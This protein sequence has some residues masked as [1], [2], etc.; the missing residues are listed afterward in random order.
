MNTIVHNVNYLPLCYSY[1]ANN[2]QLFLPNTTAMGHGV[3]Y[4]WHQN[5]TVNTGHQHELIVRTDNNHMVLRPVFLLQQTCNYKLGI[6][7]CKVIGTCA[8]LMTLEQT[9]EWIKAL[10][11][12]N[13]W[14]EADAYALNF[15]KNSITGCVLTRLNHEI[16]KF[17][18]GMLNP[19]HRIYILDLIRQLFPSLNHQDVIRAPTRLSQL[20][21]ETKNTKT[22]DPTVVR[23]FPNPAIQKPNVLLCP[24][25]PRAGPPCTDSRPFKNSRTKSKV[26]N[27]V[28]RNCG[29]PVQVGESKWN[30]NASQ[31][32]NPVN[33][34]LEWSLNSS[35]YSNLVNMRPEYSGNQI[36][37]Y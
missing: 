6:S 3:C 31:C 20:L 23:G 1:I 11:V 8:N 15:K 12:N 26:L 9:A 34:R 7:H 32:S 14:Q 16:L 35:R 22:P 24:A 17:D 29:F 19:K 36:F 33:M 2:C 10:C 37:C 28:G 5:S 21:V 25:P 27:N 30:L 4:S 13:G 18:L